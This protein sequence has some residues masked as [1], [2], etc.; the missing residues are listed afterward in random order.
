MVQQLIQQ[1]VE[2]GAPCVYYV[3][4]CWARV[5]PRHEVVQPLYGGAGKGRG[6]EQRGGRGPVYAVRRSG[7]GEI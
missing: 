1:R 3:V 5:L 6:D 7:V 4:R 2:R